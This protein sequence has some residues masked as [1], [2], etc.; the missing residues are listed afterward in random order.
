MVPKLLR[1]ETRFLSASQRAELDRFGAACRT[2]PELAGMVQNL[3]DRLLPQTA[4][5]ESGKT[6]SLKDLLAEFGFD[7]VQHDQIQA[8]LRNGRIGLSQNRLP[9]SAQIENVRSSDVVDASGGADQRFQDIGA[10]ALAAG[11]VGVVS[12]AGGAGSRWTRGAGVVKALNPFYKFGGRYRSFIEIHLAKSRRTAR[13]SGTAV[14]HVITTSYLTHSPI[15]TYLESEANCGYDG[16]LLLSPGKSI[17]L[18]M[19]PM[20]RDLRFAWEEMP[21]Q[22]LDEQKQRVRESLHAALIDW[23]RRA[24]EGSDYTEN[25]P[26]QCLHPTGHW[27]EVPNMLRNGVLLELFRQRPQLRYLMVHNIDTLGANLDPYFLGLH[28]E[29]GAAMTIEVIPRHVDDRGGG[30]ARLDGRVRLI[31]GLALPSE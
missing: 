28:I 18:R 7:R 20:A 19:I 14:P 9:A 27:Y 8:D 15:E 17:G 3:F 30:L 1:V 13:L 23:A 29:H 25:L 11:E 12:L 6:K 5:E 4:T 2:T 22:V 10:K 24:G 31:E 16:L 21:Q 26:M